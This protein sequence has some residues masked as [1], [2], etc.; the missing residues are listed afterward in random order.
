MSNTRKAIP[1][2][3]VD[4]FFVAYQQQCGISMQV[5]T[6]VE[7]R[8]SMS[9]NDV[10]RM[11]G[12]V[13]RKWPQ[14]GQRL[15]K[16]LFGLAWSGEPSMDGMLRARDDTDALDEWR[17]EF[18]D[19]FTQPPFQVLWVS[20]PGVHHL[21]FRGHHAAADGESFSFVVKEA[22]RALASSCGGSILEISL[23]QTPTL[24]EAISKTGPIRLSDVWT[25]WKYMR[26]LKREAH[27]PASA[28][29]WKRDMRPGHI[30]ECSRVIDGSLLSRLYEVAADTA[31]S[32]MWLAAAAWTQAIHRWNG[33]HNDGDQ[34]V[35]S[36]EV[37]VSIRRRNAAASVGNLISPLIL[38][39]DA[40]R[41]L[42]EIA[43]SLKQQ[44]H[45]SIRN[46]LHIAV[47]YLTRGGARLPWSLFKSLAVT[48][49]TTG[50]ATSHF[51]W[52]HDDGRFLDDVVGFSR[53]TL[54]ITRQ[55]FYTPV[56]LHMGAALSV[57]CLP[58]KM[59]FCITHRTNAI[60]GADANVLVDLLLD[61]ALGSSIPIDMVMK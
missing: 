7:I 24:Q 42:G 52:L 54:R 5:G 25:F 17:N 1:L 34:P 43:G 28:S 39:C 32:P 35:I 59:T 47:P 9:H 51:T 55:D 29:V 12:C 33:L 23:A 31:T 45:S 4:A 44:L 10:E 38:Y 18:I 6:E 30:S 20:S 36:L 19:P 56:C 46:R 60:T 2:S 15:Q 3:Q 22:L 40:S 57:L 26:W 27:H 50:F 14:L 41:P 21:S 11:L 49:S 8:G 61:A 48:T 13:L 58:E 37:P 53:G 16:R